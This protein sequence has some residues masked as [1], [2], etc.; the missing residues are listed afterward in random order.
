M[1][2]RWGKGTVIVIVTS[3]AR[4]RRYNSSSYY[5]VF[6]YGE[7]MIYYLCKFLHGKNNDLFRL[8]FGL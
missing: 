2:R 5:I 3:Y 8:S 4:L 6:L 7:K 1:L